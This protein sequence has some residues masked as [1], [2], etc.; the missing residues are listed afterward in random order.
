MPPLAGLFALQMWHN[1]NQRKKKSIGIVR[2]DMGATDD[3][4]LLQEVFAALPSAVV[5]LDEP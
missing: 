1:L 3:Y 2:V 5:V 4:S